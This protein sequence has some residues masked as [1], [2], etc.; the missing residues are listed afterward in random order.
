MDLGTYQK[1]CLI[2]LFL[3]SF[4]LLYLIYMFFT[5]LLHFLHFFYSLFIIYFLHFLYNKQ[6][7]ITLIKSFIFSYTSF[8]PYKTSY[9]HFKNLLLYFHTTSFTLLNRGFVR[10]GSPEP[11]DVKFIGFWTQVFENYKFKNQMRSLKVMAT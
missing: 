3:S 8:I 4:T 1:F 9:M 2:W 10:K 7:L 5:L 11:M 6:V